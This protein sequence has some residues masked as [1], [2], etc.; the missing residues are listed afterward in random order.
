MNVFPPV[1]VKDSINIDILIYLAILFNRYSTFWRTFGP[2]QVF[3][4]D[5]IPG[6]STSVFLSPELSRSNLIPMMR[7]EVWQPK[8]YP[9][10][11]YD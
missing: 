1:Y 11:V 7:S 10:L 5:D 4:W 9:E 8:P 3:L 2:H 6:N